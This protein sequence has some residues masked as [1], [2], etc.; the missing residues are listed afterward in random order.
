MD[1]KTKL[2]ELAGVTDSLPRVMSN[3]RKKKTATDSG[4]ITGKLASVTDTLS[5]VTTNQ[6]NTN[7]SDLTGNNDKLAGV[8]ASLSGVTIASK[9]SN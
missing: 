4:E 9:P 2:S 7:V 5:G 1:K 8:M 6:V 3:P